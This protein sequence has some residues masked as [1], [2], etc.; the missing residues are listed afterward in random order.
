MKGLMKKLEDGL[1]KAKIM[2]ILSLSQTVIR[3][4][5]QPYGQ[6]LMIQIFVLRVRKQQKT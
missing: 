2:M 3:F 4:L 1:Q 5:E 6:S